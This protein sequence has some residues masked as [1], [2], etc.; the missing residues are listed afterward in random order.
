MDF[1]RYI[2]LTRRTCNENLNKSEKV[3]NYEWCLDEEYGEIKGVLKKI[4]WHNHV[5]DDEKIKLELG[6]FMFYVARLYDIRMYDIEEKPLSVPYDNLYD[7]IH[8]GLKRELF[9][10]L[11]EPD[12]Y[13]LNQVYWYIVFICEM[14]GFDIEEIF[15]MNTDKLILRFPEKFTYDGSINRIY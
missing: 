6:D 9:Y 8:K 4:W 14:L 7:L 10:Y 3:K 5:K 11:E 1:E 13:S 2:Y 15:K 12:Q